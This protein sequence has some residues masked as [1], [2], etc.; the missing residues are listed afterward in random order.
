MFRSRYRRF[1]YVSFWPRYLGEE[2]STS[3]PTD[4]LEFVCRTPKEFL[5]ERYGLDEVLELF[6]V[7]ARAGLQR[8]LR[9]G[10]K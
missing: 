10:T 5:E 3:F 1:L 6:Q 4:W 9:K 7:R 8:E 2:L